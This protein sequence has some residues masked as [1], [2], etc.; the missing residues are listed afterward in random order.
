LFSDFTNFN[1]VIFYVLFSVARSVIYHT[2]HGT[3]GEEYE[4]VIIIME[5]QFGLDKTKF[6]DFFANSV[7]LSKKEIYIKTKNLLYVACS[8]AIKNLR[9][10][11][12]DDVTDFKVGIENIF[13]EVLEFDLTTP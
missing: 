8:R 3:K 1:I 9:V 4:N 7:E 5:N 13:D 10:F 2:Y 11:Y 6:S 12:L